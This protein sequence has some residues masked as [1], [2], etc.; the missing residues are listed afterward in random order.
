MNKRSKTTS[1]QDQPPE[2]SL[3]H[4]L[5]WLLPALLAELLYL[6]S[7]N[8]TWVWDDSIVLETQMK[9]FRSVGDVF[10]PPERIPQWPESYYR[11]VVTASY[12]LD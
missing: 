8:G 10:F 2:Q 11:P 1:P 6:P 4:H 12:L 3:S 7:L 5:F 9:A